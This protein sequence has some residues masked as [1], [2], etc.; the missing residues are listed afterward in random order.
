MTVGSPSPSPSAH[1][2]DV[3]PMAPERNGPIGCRPQPRYRQT[4][5]S[6]AALATEL[7]QEAFTPVTWRNDPRG[8]LR[9]CFA[10]L[11]GFTARVVPALSDGNADEQ[12][13][14]AAR[15]RA[16]AVLRYLTKSGRQAST[17][18]I[19]FHCRPPQRLEL[20]HRSTGRTLTR[21]SFAITVFFSPSQS[22]RRPIPAPKCAA[23]RSELT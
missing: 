15:A 11:H 12:P 1:S 6:V 20:L 4:A 5:P 16:A 2:F 13:A 14:A 9:P 8:E 3:Q 21:S 18:R 10:A 19:A 23:T 7:G 17:A 22:Y